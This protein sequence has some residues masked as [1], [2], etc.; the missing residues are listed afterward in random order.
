[1]PPLM[2]AKID[3]VG[4]K[5]FAQAREK[6][7]PD[8]RT[9]ALNKLLDVAKGSFPQADS[10][11]PAGTFYKADGDAVT[12]ILESPSVALRSAIEFMQTWYQEGLPTFPECRV[13]LDYGALDTLVVPGKVELTGKPFENIS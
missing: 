4:S 13:F 2:V 8:V 7:E 6:Q 5:V 11:F 9:R 10:S 3:L 12:Y 1:M